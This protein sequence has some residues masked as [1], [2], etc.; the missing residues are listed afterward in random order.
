MI[1][2]F[3]RTLPPVLRR[4]WLWTLATTAG[5][6]VY[7]V[8]MTFVFHAGYPYALP[9]FTGEDYFF[10]FTVYHERSL[11]FRTPAFWDAFGYPFTYPAPL[12]LV[13]GLLYKVPHVLRY[14]LLFYVLLCLGGAWL[15]ARALTRRGVSQTAAVLFTATVLLCSYPLLALFRAGNTEGLVALLAG[16]GIYA[17][18]RDRCW[19]GATLIAVAGTMKIFP[20]IL[21]ALLLS[22]RRYREFV[23]G[24][25][26]AGVVSVSSLAVLGPSITIAQRHIEDGIVYVRQAFILSLSTQVMEVS[27]S[28]FT[29]L[30]IVVALLYRH[31]HR[32]P[33]THAE[34]LARSAGEQGVLGTVFTV[35]LVCAA[36]LGI[37][38][39]FGWIR[40]LPM[41][42][43][44]L[45]LTALA[46]LLPPLSVDYALVHLLFPFAL[47]CLYA[48]DRWRS[49]LRTPGLVACFASVALIF[50]YQTYLVWRF[51]FASC[52]RTLGLVML[53]AVAMRFPF[54]WTWMGEA[55]T[56]E[57]PSLP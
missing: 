36:V 26:V 32:V 20:F 8:A 39:Y 34:W 27:H 6:A 57:Q 23:W 12:G 35:Y 51:Y 4:F 30:K 40:R 42:N 55:E 56:M 38:L 31:W 33:T 16:A 43:Q 37:A 41:L 25:V 13:Y 1:E 5:S 44:L 14:Y 45:A 50:S 9:P 21:L 28:L 10:D 11:H 19:L 15:L 52:V 29:P 2:R 49:G 47:L 53:V 54:R 7:S 17:V 46:V 22:K 3:S 18:L 24:L 48:T